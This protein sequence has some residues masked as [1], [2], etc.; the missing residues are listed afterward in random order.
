MGYYY[1]LNEETGKVKF[2]YDYY[3]WY[4]VISF[5]ADYGGRKSIYKTE[6]GVFLRDE[7]STAG[8]YL[9]GERITGIAHL[10]HGDILQIGYDQIFEY[11][12][13]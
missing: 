1:D 13:R 2:N 5:T 8:T 9:N 4:P 3:G 10:H 6:E 12:K 11:R 7:N